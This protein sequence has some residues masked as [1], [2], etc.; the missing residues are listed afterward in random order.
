MDIRPQK[1]INLKDFGSEGEIT[2]EPLTFRR[3]KQLQNNIGLCM[4]VKNNEVEPTR[5]GDVMIYKV[6]AYIVS[7]PFRY[8]TI[9]GFYNFMDKMDRI[10]PDN[11][12]RLFSALNDA[13]K[14]LGQEESSPLDNSQTT[15]PL[16]DTERTDC[17]S[18]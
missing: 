10:S 1:T 3:R 5:M 6:M 14:E 18:P 8:D 4:N 13:I 12:E 15:S 2:L 17:L 16:S 9:E 7:A 11:G